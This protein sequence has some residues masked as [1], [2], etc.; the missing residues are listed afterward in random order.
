[1]VWGGGFPPR[2]CCVGARKKISVRPLC[3][4]LVFLYCII[5]VVAERVLRDPP[6]P[7][8]PP[9]ASPSVCLCWCMLKLGVILS[10]SYVFFTCSLCSYMF[11][12]SLDETE[13]RRAEKC[14]KKSLIVFLDSVTSV[15]APSSL[16][17]HHGGQW[18]PELH[19]RA[20]QSRKRLAEWMPA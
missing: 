20:I 2:Y 4:T 15:P 6:P 12:F 1:M 14:L 17:S 10:I 9:A 11:L 13:K 16:H 18:R 5:Y 19:H 7:P 8:P 3:C